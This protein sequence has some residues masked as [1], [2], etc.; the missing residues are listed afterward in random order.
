MIKSLLTTIATVLVF[1]FSA[2]S[3]EISPKYKHIVQVGYGYNHFNLI[4]P[5]IFYGSTDWEAF[6]TKN[7]VRP[8]WDEKM[9]AIS[10]VNFHYHVRIKERG[11]FGLTATTDFY[12]RTYGTVSQDSVLAMKESLQIF[13]LMPNL[14]Y[15]YL[16][17]K[18]V[19]LYF[20]IEAGL[21]LLRVKNSESNYRQTY[22]KGIAII[23]TFNFSP[24][25]LR[26]KYKVSPY[27]QLNIGSRR[28]I[29]VGVSYQFGQ[30]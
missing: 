3:K 11:S 8:V 2:Y 18:T 30:R 24:F 14:Y 17:N 28:W 4:Y 12:R 26:L 6:D 9:L 19:R 13:T 16:N 7:T 15:H 29:E 10:S 23:P 5:I 20:G 22:D 1:L 25:G 27:F 21:M